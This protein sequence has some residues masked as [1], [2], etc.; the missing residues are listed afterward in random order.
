MAAS[1]TPRSMMGYRQRL[2][3]SSPSQGP[4]VWWLLHTAATV[5]LNGT[6]AAIGRKASALRSKRLQARRASLRSAVLRSGVAAPIDRERR[7]GAPVPRSPAAHALALRTSCRV[8]RAQMSARSGRKRPADDGAGCC[9][10]NPWFTS[11]TVRPS[12]ARSGAVRM[13]CRSRSDLDGQRTLKMIFFFFLCF[14]ST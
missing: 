7:T 2:S 9:D 11:F 4:R 6:R 13:P 3:L 8:S 12:S 5:L 1:P 14:S 10:D